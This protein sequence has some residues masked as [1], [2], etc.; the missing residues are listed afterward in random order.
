V[1]AHPTIREQATFLAMAPPTNLWDNLIN[2][3]IGGTK[4]PL[5]FIHDGYG[6]VEYGFQ[7]SQFI[8]KDRA[9][10]GFQASGLNGT[11]EPLE[12]VK[13][14]AQHYIKR[15]LTHQPEGVYH[16]GAYS[17]GSTVAF[18]MAR[19][20]KAQ[21]KQVG[22]VAIFDSYP[23]RLNRFTYQRIGLHFIVR[24]LINLIFSSSIP[25]MQKMK[26]VSGAIPEII[27]ENWK[28]V[29]CRSKEITTASAGPVD[30]IFRT[31]KK[32]NDSYRFSSYA[33]PLLF[34]RAIENPA[35]YL[36]NS[37][38]GWGR[39]ATQVEVHDLPCDHKSLFKNKE[40]VKI[41]ANILEMHLAEYENGVKSHH[42][43]AHSR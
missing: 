2:I 41:V 11:E 35:R 19:Q 43:S 38:F 1:F 30:K 42:N 29:K 23:L 37:D 26:I 28:R 22:M 40:N 12:G 21:G 24:S 10:Y 32:S 25:Y 14:I 8:D 3:R 13:T 6:G 17:G 20:L 18:E 39:Y 4:P 7:I 16:L 33:G 36:R 27:H 15:L 9:I 5:Y 34:I 31:M